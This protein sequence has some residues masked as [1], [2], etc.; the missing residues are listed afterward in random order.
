MRRD[1]TGPNRSN[2][3]AR[4]WTSSFI[5]DPRW[6]DTPSATHEVH[7]AL[8]FATQASTAS[9]YVAP[10]GVAVGAALSFAMLRAWGFAGSP[11]GLAVA[12]TGVW[13]QLAML[14][15]PTIA[16]VLLTLTGDSHTALD[17]IAYLGL[18]ILVVVVAAFA[19]GLSTPKLARWI[20][21]LTA[22]I[23][24]RGL[25]LVRRGPVN[26]DGKSFVR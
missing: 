14:S 2:T 10:G 15:F 12:V 6:Q 1:S 7:P 3:S 21:D 5:R 26:W 18:A 17:T 11:V 13:N 25:R 24:S 16:L 22:R 8:R 23:V 9:T 20:G 19:A 4:L